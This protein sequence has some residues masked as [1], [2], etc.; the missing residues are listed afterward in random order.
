MLATRLLIS[1]KDDPEEMALTVNGKKR[2]FSKNDFVRFAVNLGLND[3]QIENV[4][5]RFSK[6]LP[7]ISPVIDRGF[8][9]GHTAA[10]FKQSVMERAARLELF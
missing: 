3:K 4:F 5:R 8:L 6:A 1:E 2:K 9:P 10:A 7:G